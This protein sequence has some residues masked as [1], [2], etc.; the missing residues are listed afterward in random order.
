MRTLRALPTTDAIDALRKVPRAFTRAEMTSLLSEARLRTAVERGDVVRILPDTYVA[1]EHQYSWAA[2]VD[3]ALSWA[4]PG[5]MLAG[6]SALFAWT[7]LADAPTKVDLLVPRELRKHQV[8]GW[9]TLRRTTY[10]ISPVKAG[11]LPVAPVAFAI[12]QC[13][14]ELTPSEQSDV[15]FGAV[16]RRLTG[17][18]NLRQV[19]STMP[20]IRS[21]RA[22]TSRVAA[23]ELGAES[24]LEEH[25]LRSVFTGAH[26]D[27]FKR[28][29]ELV[30]EGRRYRL[31]MYDPFTRTAVELD[32][33]RWHGNQEQRLRDIRRDADL[34]SAG[35]LT[36]RLASSDLVD[37]PE[38]CR[39]TVLETI[40]RRR[41]RRV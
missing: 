32:G 18:R 21:R 41:V 24:W 36:V 15:V 8:P 20:R 7:L 29:H 3:A 28:Q 19:L 23:A 10:S 38:W 1:A 5:S 22:L 4:G 40:A 35:V 12:A 17:V 33:A 39:H 26:F 34:A 25:S 6:Q 16:A 14:A 9:L 11:D 31:D 30:H 27:H 2:R 13:Y 37:K